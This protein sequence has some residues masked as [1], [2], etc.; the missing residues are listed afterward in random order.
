MLLGLR[1]RFLVFPCVSDT[2]VIAVGFDTAIV[3]AVAVISTMVVAVTSVVA[4][5]IAITITILVT[6]ARIRFLASRDANTVVVADDVD[7]TLATATAN[8]RTIVI[9]HTN[10]RCYAGVGAVPDTTAMSSASWLVWRP[11]FRIR[12][13]ALCLFCYYHYRYRAR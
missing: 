10:N 5:A 11:P 2:D 12:K 13:G 7:A 4:V 8:S 1:L 6:I 3:I 9:I